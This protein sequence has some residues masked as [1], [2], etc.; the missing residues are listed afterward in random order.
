MQ[1]GHGDEIV[2]ADANFPADTY[3]SKVIR[4]DGDSIVQLLESI[5]P[6]FVLD[7]FIKD[8][9]YLMSVVANKGTEPEIWET[10]RKIIEKNDVEQSFNDFSFLTREDFYERSK[11]ASLIVSTG[12]R[13]RYANIILKMGVVD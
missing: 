2:F 10:Y 6:Y 12:E 8:N 5:M 3:G 1:M 4:A 11:K 9:V 7:D 13:A